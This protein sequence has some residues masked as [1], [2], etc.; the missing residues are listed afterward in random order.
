MTNSEAEKFAQ[1]WIQCFNRREIQKVLGHFADACTFTSPRAPAFAGKATLDSRDEL[2][3]YWTAAVESTRSLHFTLDR[4]VNDPSSDTLVILYI[5]QI[6][7]QRN[8]AAEI[9]RFDQSGRIIH[10]EAMYGAPAPVPVEK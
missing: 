4:V 2:S 7:N 9:Y 10:G 8:R 5:A 1:E 6:D 3:A